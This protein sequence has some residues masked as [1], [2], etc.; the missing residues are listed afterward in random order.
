MVA[1]RT[2]AVPDARALV[3][4]RVGAALGN[5]QGG[6]AAGVVAGA[7]AQCAA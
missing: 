7:G 5:D 6:L 2:Q 1:T 3:A 4:A